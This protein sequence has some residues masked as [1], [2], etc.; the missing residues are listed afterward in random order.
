VANQGKQTIMLRQH[1]IMPPR[2][3]CGSTDVE[4]GYKF[5]RHGYLQVCN[6]CGLEMFWSSDLITSEEV[7]EMC[8]A[9]QQAQCKSA[10]MQGKGKPLP[11]QPQPPDGRKT[12][13]RRGSEAG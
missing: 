13:Q 2:C 1:N 8:A 4:H 11:L 5:N 3:A 10:R 6:V 7:D 9:Y 12:R